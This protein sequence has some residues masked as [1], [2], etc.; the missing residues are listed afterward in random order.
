VRKR[1][2]SIFDRLSRSLCVIGF[3][4]PPSFLLFDFLPPSDPTY[5]F[6]KN[7]W[8]TLRPPFLRRGFISFLP[9]THLVLS[10][11]ACDIPIPIPT[12]VLLSWE[13]VASE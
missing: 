12:I 5:L 9:L 4:S 10:T 13:I 11:P 8:T 2:S 3:S 6:I 7:I 1:V